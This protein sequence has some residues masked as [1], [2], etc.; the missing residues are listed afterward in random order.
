MLVVGLLL[1]ILVP[2]SSFAQNGDLGFGVGVGGKF[3]TLGAGFD[4]AVPISSRANV[5]GGLRAGLQSRL[6]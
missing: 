5:R 2:A 6:S 1:G 3:S 4:V